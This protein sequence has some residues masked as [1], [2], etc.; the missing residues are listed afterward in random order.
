[1]GFKKLWF[2]LLRRTAVRTTVGEVGPNLRTP[3]RKS[4]G[5]KPREPAQSL[6]ALQAH[7]HPP[8]HSSAPHCTAPR[9]SSAEVP[10]PGPQGSQTKLSRPCPPGPRTG[11]RRP[12][13]PS[14]ALGGPGLMGAGC[15]PES[16]AGTGGQKQRGRVSEHKPLERQRAPLAS[17]SRSRSVFS[18]PLVLTRPRLL[19]PPGNQG[20][21]PAA[22]RSR[23]RD[24]QPRAAREAGAGVVGPAHGRMGAP[25]GS[26]LRS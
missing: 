26:P 4:L 20:P 7:R 23:D 11:G 8:P 2:L 22:L 16:P 5:P 3:T 6:E 15:S 9:P 12:G 24:P 10:Q 14:R 21:S 1:M 17:A 18:N 13:A 19:P 25:S